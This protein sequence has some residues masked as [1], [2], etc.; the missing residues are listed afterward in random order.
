M[1]VLYP[2]DFI[3]LVLI[4]EMADV[5]IK[6]PYLAFLLIAS[7]IEFLGKC[8]DTNV[9][10]WDWY[11]KKYQKYNREHP[12]F[13]TA[14]NKLFKPKYKK[15]LA[16]YNLRHQ[17][18]N[19]MVHMYTP[20]AGIGLT[21]IKHDKKGEITNE[22]HPKEEN[23]KLTLVIEYFYMDFVEACK[24]ILAKEFNVFDKMK[25]PLLKIPE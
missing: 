7:G 24:K 3:K 5:V 13:D 15:L 18:R 2:K 16:K 12:P 1:R 14:I 4:D 23:G 6:H 11:D 22:K 19:G 21:Q 25:K 8:F 10:E 20:K 9:Q 17:L